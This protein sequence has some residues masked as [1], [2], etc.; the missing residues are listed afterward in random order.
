VVFAAM[1]PAANRR[2]LDVGCGYGQL[3]RALRSM[4]SSDVVGIDVTSAFIERLRASEPQGRWE[5]GSLS[6]ESFCK[7]LGRFDLVTLVEVLQYV[8]V[9]ATL[10]AAW[11]LLEPGGRVLAVVPNRECPIVGRA[12]AR[13]D[14][15]YLPPTVAELIGIGGQLGG[16][17]W[18]IQGMFFGEDQVIAP[19]R[20]SPWTQR[21][22]FH[23]PPNRL[24]F[25][26]VK[27]S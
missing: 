10:R 25:A 17:S 21:P 23:E 18:G 27:P 24:V 14:G 6:D 12:M 2:C 15:S 5:V 20:V 8:P 3:A 26:A 22:D 19:Y 11:Q 16:A 9:E 7:S 4:G 1:G 13:F